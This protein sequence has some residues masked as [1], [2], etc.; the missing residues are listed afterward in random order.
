MKPKK[1]CNN[2]KLSP[3]DIDA[4]ICALPLVANA[5]AG[6]PEQTM[7][8][9]FFCETVVNKLLSKVSAYSADELRVISVAIDFAL[10]VLSGHGN[11]FVSMADIDADW[12]QDLSQY[13]FAYNRLKVHF[14]DLMLR[15][16]R[17]L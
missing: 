4:I 7:Q 9:Q 8:N 3:G 17:D 2:I 13:L 5:D 1:I 16:K 10:D 15:I 6:S 11:E 14:A 12:R